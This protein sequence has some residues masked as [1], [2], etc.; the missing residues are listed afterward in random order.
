MEDLELIFSATY[1]DTSC[2]VLHHTP[3]VH[4]MTNLNSGHNTC[5]STHLTCYDML[6]V[7]ISNK[8]KNSYT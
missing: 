2:L 5:Y 8:I 1:R 7:I 3:V 6:A 4:K